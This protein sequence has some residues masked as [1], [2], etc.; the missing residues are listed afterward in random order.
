LDTYLN[1]FFTVLALPLGILLV[2]Y[3]IYLLSRGEKDHGIFLIVLG[4]LLLIAVL[5]GY[6]GVWH[7]RKLKEKLKKPEDEQ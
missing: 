5:S 6:T 2:G 4:G 7:R 1:C 3:G